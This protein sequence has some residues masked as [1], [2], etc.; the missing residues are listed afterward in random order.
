MAKIV[1]KSNGGF[2]KS[3]AAQLSLVTGETTGTITPVDLLQF[4]AGGDKRV[5]GTSTDVASEVRYRLF[6]L[7]I[8]VSNVGIS[9][10]DTR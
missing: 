6:G 7:V 10:A 4:T 9:G 1:L 3:A 2:K 8:P 5:V